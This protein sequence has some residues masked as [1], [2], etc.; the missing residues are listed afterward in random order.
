MEYGNQSI[1]VSRLGRAEDA[2]GGNVRLIW[3]EQ[4]GERQEAAI[5][6]IIPAT[7][8]H[9]AATIALQA[10]IKAGIAGTLKRQYLA[11][12]AAI[13]PEQSPALLWACLPDGTGM[14]HNSAWCA[15][16]A[17]T[18]EE[19]RTGWKFTAHP[20][21]RS[22]LL[23]PWLRSLATGEPYEVEVR[24]RNLTGEYH[25][26]RTRAV[27]VFEHGKLVKWCGEN[28]LMPYR[29]STLDGINAIKQK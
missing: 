13:D 28:S 29:T 16:Y 26:Y 11:Q 14:R 22:P 12:Q 19:A 24:R 5:D 15:H 10:A 23:E 1:Y 7:A 25:W 6:I 9:D 20:D 2:G 21:D 3:T 4:R 27:P 18:E 17:M 8:L